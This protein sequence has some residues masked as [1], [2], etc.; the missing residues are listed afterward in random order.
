M[1]I[2]F[3]S[4]LFLLPS[5]EL[6]AKEQAKIDK[7]LTLL[8]NSGVSIIL[9]KYIKNQTKQGGRPHKNFYRLFATILYGFAFGN[10]T[11]RE[12]AEAIKY[13]LRYIYLM[14]QTFVSYTTIQSFIAN[15]IVPEAYSIF[16][17]INIQIC[18]EMN[19]EF[20]DAFIDGT[21]QE[22][23]SNKYKFVWKPTTFHQ[24]LS[25]TANSMIRSLNLIDKYNDEIL[26]RS[27]TVA[28][29]ITNLQ[30]KKDLFDSKT[31]NDSMKGL[32]SILTKV[33]EYEE[34]ENICG[35]NRKSYYKTDHDAT[36]MCLKSDYYSGLGSNMHAAYNV[37]I[38]V[39]KGISLSYYISSSR[40]DIT[41]FIPTLAIFSSLYGK[42]P[43]RI[44][45]DAGYGSLENY[46]FLKD[47][48]IENFVKY[49]SWE[50]NVSGSNPDCYRLNNDDLLICIN[51]NIGYPVT[52]ENRHHK[53]AGSIF[54]RVSGCN[55][56][57]FKSYCKRFMRNQNEDFK[58]FEVIV[59][60]Q[61]LKQ[62]A[63]QNLLSQKGIE[64]R[65]NRSIQVEGVFGIEKQDY[66]YKRFRRRGNNNVS[67]EYML[68]LLGLNI[69]KLFR[70]YETGKTNK[71]WTAPINLS[72]EQF[73][74]LSAKR[75]SKKG[76]R[77]NKN[78]Y[79]TDI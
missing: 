6:E 69:A 33:L 38:L 31:F 73:K 2:F 16:G 12:I 39:I 53:K 46:R 26:I 23:N 27:S 45:A 19:I 60:L 17:L 37:Q 21:K 35:P 44:C 4:K 8:D 77:M 78:A 65:V 56:C 9:S 5:I 29:A 70:Y 10:D 71:Y 25:I 51:G 55:D 14:E 32:T 41:D 49:F 64:M 66:E 11:L 15:V 18:K 13:D 34:K 1:G 47:N 61:K 20:E 79:K 52:I 3:D 36:A 58:I 57:E 30:S 28:I 75:L 7:F 43:K 63:E 76:N 48:N 74:K 50:G 40:A 24:R 62:E 68:S 67:A 72:P 54:Y 22:A 42:Y 59:E